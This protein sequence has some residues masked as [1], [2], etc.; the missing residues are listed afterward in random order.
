MMLIIRT[1]QMRAFEQ[2]SLHRF[3][4]EMLEHLK[5]FSPRHAGVI[6]EA[7]IRRVIELGMERARKYEF[8]NQGPVRFY[9][10]LMFMY[11]SEFDTDPQ[12]AWAAEVLNEPNLSDQMTRADYLHQQAMQYLDMVIGADYQ[13][14]KAALRR[15]SQIQ[16]QALSELGENFRDIILKRLKEIYPQKCDYVGEARMRLLIQ[17]GL[18]AAGKYSISSHAGSALLMGLMFAFGHGCLSDPQFPWIESTLNNRA[19]EEE[20]RIER[21]FDKTMAYL[22]RGLANLEER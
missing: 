13:Y 7:R 19:T 22:A 16:F 18:Q 20:Q 5:K 9:M 14:E 12:L 21:L 10:E 2:S 15:L 1:E 3:A 4:E 6:G 17:R 8:S 11:G